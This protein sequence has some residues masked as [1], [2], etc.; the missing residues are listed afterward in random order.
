MADTQDSGPSA[1]L[2]VKVW[3]IWVRLFH[4]F[5]VA[6][7][8]LSYLTGEIGGLDFTVPG[9]DRFI[10][11]MNVHVLSGIT[12][13]GLVTFRIIWGFAGSTT[14]RFR[15]FL[16]G[17]SVILGYAKSILKGPVAFF[18]GH[19]PAGGAVVMIILAALFVQ[20]GSGL[21]SQDDS[22]FATKGPLAFLVTDETSKEV[23]GFH[24]Q[25]W[26]YA[27]VTLI[28]L[29]IVANLFYWLIKKQDLIV[30]MFTG[31][32]RLPDGESEP[33]LSFAKTGLGL[34]IAVGV[35]V[36]MWLIMNAEAL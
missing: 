12:I 10:S 16:N 18:A 11:N 33:K 14:A 5:L 27:I 31:H 2:M 29:H 34:A 6:F 28:V 20:G 32:R 9:T 30:A 17:P 25:W 19:N 36:L 22:F 23:T 15:N 1:P 4:W 13:L 21:F 35:A 3:D 24:K 26:E 7:I 8:A